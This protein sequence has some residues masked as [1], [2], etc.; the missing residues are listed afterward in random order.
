MHLDWEDA[1]A[2]LLRGDSRALAGS[3]GRLVGFLATLLIVDALVSAYAVLEGSYPAFVPLGSPAAYLNIYIHVPTAMVSYVLYTGAFVSAILYLLRRRQVYDRYVVGFLIVATLY[4]AYTLVSGSFWA[5]ESWGK[6]WN[7]DPRETGVLLL[8]LVYLVYF[9]LRA[10][11]TDPDRAPV[12]SS[13]YAVAAYAMVPISYAAPRIAESS[14]H[15]TQAL[16]Q[17]FM[18]DPAVRAIFY[19]KILLVLAIGLLSVQAYVRAAG[20]GVEYARRLRLAGIAAGLIIVAT[21][22]YMATG[23]LGGTVTRVYGVFPSGNGV[24][25]T[26]RLSGGFVNITYTGPIDKYLVDGKVALQGHVVRLGGLSATVASALSVLRPGC[27][28]VD[29]LL[30]GLLVSGL[31]YIVARRLVSGGAGNSGGWQ[32]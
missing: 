25:L 18:Q 7:W 3:V 20:A 29:T 2:V 24:V 17:D 32:G 31:A 15:P 14:L 16:L 22:V 30:Y 6:A 28:I 12:V 21:A 26:V 23:Y 8:F 11:I 13:V 27:V 10:S 5:A 4:A 9:A 19:S 1:T